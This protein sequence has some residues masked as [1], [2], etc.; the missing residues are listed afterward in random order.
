MDQIDLIMEDSRNTC[1]IVQNVH[2]IVHGGQI[3]LTMDIFADNMD[4]FMDKWTFPWTFV[5]NGGQ[6]WTSMDIRG[7]SWTTDILVDICDNS[8]RTTIVIELLG[9]HHVGDDY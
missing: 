2:E 3:G 6:A 9:L 4:N 8:K 1:R 7:H 5:D